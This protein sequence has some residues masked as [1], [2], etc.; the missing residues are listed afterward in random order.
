VR[1]FGRF[2]ASIGGRPIAWIRRRDAQIVKYLLLRPNGTAS[3]AELRQT[4][5]PDTDFGLA[6]QSLRTACS[7][8]RKAVAA[9]VG[10]EQVDRYFQARSDVTINL[11]QTALD[12]RRFSA[13]VGDGDAELERGN[14]HEA[15]AH[16][17]AAERLYSGELL[18]GE[19]P[20]PW[21][22]ARAEMFKSLY[23]GVLQ[24]LADFCADA[25]DDAQAMTYRER[26]RRLESPGEAD[27]RG[28]S[29]IIAVS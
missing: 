5:W 21:Y 1:M 26:L 14:T 7:N 22:V 25:G 29:A 28:N 18:S 12:V 20:E 23:V 2:E 19:L 27:A 9:L 3:R 10:Y 4:F 15:R 17:A 24:R 13:H 6:T 16:Y 11:G 8:I